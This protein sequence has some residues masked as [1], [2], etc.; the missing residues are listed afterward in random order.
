MTGFVVHCYYCGCLDSMARILSTL[1]GL[2]IFLLQGL[3]I[4]ILCYGY[5]DRVKILTV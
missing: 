5:G 2:Y 1:D 4:R 3:H